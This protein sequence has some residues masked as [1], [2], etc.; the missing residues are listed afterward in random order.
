MLYSDTALSTSRFISQ[1]VTKANC[2][3]ILTLSLIVNKTRLEVFEIVECEVFRPIARE[4][5]YLMD[6]K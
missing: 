1:F 2:C 3:P 5:K 6:F 4:R